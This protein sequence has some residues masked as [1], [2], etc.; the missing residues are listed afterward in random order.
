MVVFSVTGLSFGIADRVLGTGLDFEVGRGQC[1]ALMAPSG[2]GKTTLLRTLAGLIDPLEGSLSLEGRGPEA[3]GWPAWRRRVAYV[4]QRPVMFG[5]T[6]LDNLRRPFLYRSAG[7]GFDEARTRQWLERLGL[8]QY[9]DHAAERLSV[10]EQQ[11]V[12]LLRALQL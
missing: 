7:T 9:A 2:A 12:S 10:G 1:L 4:A 11:R 8:A 5:G 3:W 6:V